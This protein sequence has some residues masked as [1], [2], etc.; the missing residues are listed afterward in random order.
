MKQHMGLEPC[1]EYYLASND[2]VDTHG[3]KVLGHWTLSCY[4]RDWLSSRF[5]KSCAG[6]RSEVSII[7]S[8]IWPDAQVDHPASCRL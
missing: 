6:A 7:V 5:L 4:S 1:R 2:A 3:K 8:T